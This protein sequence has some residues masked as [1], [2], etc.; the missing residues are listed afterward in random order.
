MNL[1]EDVEDGTKLRGGVGLRNLGME[2]TLGEAHGF[3][4]L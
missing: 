2:E 1:G 4:S 3:L